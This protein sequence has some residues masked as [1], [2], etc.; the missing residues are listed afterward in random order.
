[1][2]YNLLVSYDLH[3]PQQNYEAVRAR[4]EGLGRYAHL[5]QSVY[6]LH[7]A[8]SPEQVAAHIQPALDSDDKLIVAHVTRAQLVGYGQD[9]ITAIN[10]VW[11]LAA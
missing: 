10:G 4:I 11:D 3:R 1:M 2:A 7:S 8:L 6:Y 5:Q 9:V